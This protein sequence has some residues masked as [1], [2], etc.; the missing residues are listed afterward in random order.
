MEASTHAVPE[1]EPSSVVGETYRVDRHVAHGGS[2]V[3]YAARHVEMDRR[4]ALKVL[5]LGSDVDASA[6]E[7]F[8]QEARLA[9]QINHPNVVTIYQFGQDSRG[10]LYIAMEWLEGVS[11]SAALDERGSLDPLEVAQLGREIARG[12]AAVHARDVLHRDLKPS[13]VMLAELAGWEETAKLLDFGVAKSLAGT[14]EEQ[15]RITQEGEFVGTPRY[16]PPELIRGEELTARMDIYSTGLLMWEALTGEPAVSSVVFQECCAQ[17]LADEPWRLNESI[18]CPTV[19]R[20]V[21]HRSLRKDPD[22]RFE[23]CRELS[24]A[25]GEAVHEIASS[26]DG[27]SSGPMAAP[28]TGSGRGTYGS[29]WMKLLFAVALGVAVLGLAGY[30]GWI[31]TLDDRGE[32]GAGRAGAAPDGSEGDRRSETPQTPEALLDRLERSGWTV[33]RAGAAGGTRELYR[34]AG[35]GETTSIVIDRRES[36]RKRE[37][38]TFQFSEF[39]VRVRAGGDHVS[40][41][42][43]RLV[44]KLW[45][46]QPDR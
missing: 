18:D 17:H 24:R 12:L 41:T 27:T 28:N 37:S 19:L 16:A 7:R 30:Q 32:G 40:P 11:L 15:I 45:R 22:E 44:A 34:I 10:L 35:A 6:L 39:S 4:V 42:T 31:S 25:L 13:N 38:A 5:P 26:R 43:S 3:V 33:E 21:V 36:T 29:Q 23:S 46:L 14:E 8:S 20:E 2:S 1:L 9:C